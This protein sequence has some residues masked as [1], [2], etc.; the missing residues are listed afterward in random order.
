MTKNQVAGCAVLSVLPIGMLTV[1]VLTDS[2]ADF[3]VAMGVS[4]LIFLIIN[5]GFWLLD[6]GNR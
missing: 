2:V 3:L 6:R 4:A 5:T 1:A